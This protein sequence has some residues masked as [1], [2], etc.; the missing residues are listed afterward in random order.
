MN[1]ININ[2]RKFTYDGILSIMSGKFFVNGKEM[3]EWSKAATEQKEINVNINGQIQQLS[4]DC[5]NKVRVSGNCGLVNT[6]SGDIDIS[7]NVFGHVKTVSGNIR[8]SNV[9]GEMMTPS[10]TITQRQQLL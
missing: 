10:G 5:C 8:C 7:G 3:K 6:V 4:I 1:V 9:C 2:G